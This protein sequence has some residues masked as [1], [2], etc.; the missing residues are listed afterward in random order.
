MINIYTPVIIDGSCYTA[1]LWCE[2][3]G[4]RFGWAL[5]DLLDSDSSPV[6]AD[7]S[8]RLAAEESLAERTDEIRKKLEEA[9][10]MRTREDRT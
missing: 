8:L 7:T 5:I 9:G 1:R 6:I 2:A 3:D 10:A 4:D